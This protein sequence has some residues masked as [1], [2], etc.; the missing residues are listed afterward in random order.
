MVRPVY[1][2]PQPK[3]IYVQ[4]PSIVFHREEINQLQARIDALELELAYVL[5]LV[6]RSVTSGI[7]DCVAWEDEDFPPENVEHSTGDS[8]GINMSQALEKKAFG[9][10][11]KVRFSFP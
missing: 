11:K 4:T 8:F 6:R 3:Q 5:Q 7:H 10:M 2:S 1:P 9:T